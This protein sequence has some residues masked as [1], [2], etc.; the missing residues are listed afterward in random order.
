MTQDEALQTLGL[1]EGASADEITTAATQKKTDI[2]DKIAAAPTNSLKAKFQTMLDKVTEAEQL[3][4]QPSSVRNSSPLSQTKMADLPGAA[5]MGAASA[6]LAL[7]VGDKLSHDR[8]EIKEL[9][10][11][12][13][14]GSVFHAYDHTRG[15]DIAIKVLLPAMVAN[16]RAKERFLNEAKLSSRLSH[17]NITNVFDVQEDGQFTFLTM[18]LLDGQDV[19]QLMDNRKLSRQQF[20]EKEAINL[21]S[22]LADALGYAHEYT[23]HRDIKPENIWI[24]EDGQYK[25]MDFGIARVMS[26]TQRTQTGMAMGTAYYMAPEQLSGTTSVDGRAD[27]Y[28]LGILLYELLTGNIPTGRF[29]ALREV[30]KDLSKKFAAAIDK[31]LEPDPEDR[32]SDMAA[33]KVALSGGSQGVS[34]PKVSMPKLKIGGVGKKTGIITAL[35]SVVIIGV[36]AG[37]GVLGSAWE[38]IRPMSEAEKLAIKQD[39]LMLQSSV[40]SARKQIESIQVAF[41]SE[42]RES[43]SELKRIN[44]DLSRSR[45]TREK[46]QL[47]KEKK[48]SEKI[49]GEAEKKLQFIQRN[50]SDEK[51]EFENSSNVTVADTFVREKEYQQATKILKPLDVQYKT[52]LASLKITDKMMAQVESLKEAKQKW[53]KIK[54]TYVCDSSVL[55]SDKEI[56]DQGILAGNW[57]PRNCKIFAEQ[58][59]LANDLT[60]KSGIVLRSG[61]WVKALRMQ[62]AAEKL[63][64]ENEKSFRERN[65]YNEKYSYSFFNYENRKYIRPLFK[66]DDIDPVKYPVFSSRYGSS[67]KVNPLLIKNGHVYGDYLQASILARPFF[68]LFNNR[69]NSPEFKKEYQKR[70][71]EL[72]AVANKLEKKGLDAGTYYKIPA[73]MGGLNKKGLPNTFNEKTSNNDKA[74]ELINKLLSK[75]AYSKNKTLLEFR[76]LIYIQKSIVSTDNKK[77]LLEKAYAD[78]AKAIALIKSG[79]YSSYLNKLEYPFLA[80]GAYYQLALNDESNSDLKSAAKNH[81][82]AIKKAYRSKRRKNRKGDNE[83][84]LVDELKNAHPDSYQWLLKHKDSNAFVLN[85]YVTLLISTVNRANNFNDADIDEIAKQIKRGNDKGVKA[86]KEAL[87]AIYRSK[88][89]EGHKKMLADVLGGYQPKKAFKLLKELVDV[90]KSSEYKGK[91]AS[92]YMRGT[93]TRKN[94]RKGLKILEQLAKEKGEKASENDFTRIASGY[95]KLKGKANYKKAFKWFKK[96]D[97]KAPKDS[98]INNQLGYLTFKGYGVTKN[99]K[100]AHKYF[101]TSAQA[102]SVSSMSWVIPN[103]AR[104][105]GV[106]KNKSK[107]WYWFNKY[108]KSATLK[109][110]KDDISYYRKMV[111]RAFK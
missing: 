2:Q 89:P 72:L 91:L 71:G 82:L 44:R 63:L 70:V 66:F 103:Y 53:R 93:G 41:K 74:F 3:L 21:A 6:E 46:R 107:A 92:A 15:E 51:R 38:S 1:P 12:G 85:E 4:T 9:I 105:R 32:F 52:K 62:L 54:P 73:Y 59:Q 83:I 11:Q 26:N 94:V 80:P 99:L 106:S 97:K 29:K 17:P 100:K 45:S 25:L 42:I 90:N 43:K 36:L 102:G 8:Y 28:A 84:P 47:R 111:E 75:S 79:S 67:Q 7:Q 16:A 27:Q 96:A 24:T 57:K 87:Y 39:A 58:L 5:P 18:E 64:P 33:F 65:I 55:L 60:R 101:L 34:M 104:G 20:T 40:K 19:R 109:Q 30:R 37:T 56:I 98:Y 69:K 49:I 110:H 78:F 81:R 50:L 13:G 22:M 95:K 61:D 76:G 86:S 14:M 88:K 31:T 68:S 48:K 77:T 35:A 23:V 10:G 108:K